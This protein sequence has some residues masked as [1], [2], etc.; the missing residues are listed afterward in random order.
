MMEF[1]G[2]EPIITLRHTSCGFAKGIPEKEQFWLEEHRK[3]AGRY[4]TTLL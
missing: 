3:R 1:D 2:R 4:D